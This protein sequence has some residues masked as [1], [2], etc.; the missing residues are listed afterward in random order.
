MIRKQLAH[1][2]S[3]ALNYFFNW[4]EYT[5]SQLFLTGVMIGLVCKSVI[6]TV[7]NS[8][9]Y[10]ADT[11]KENVRRIKEHNEDKDATLFG[12]QFKHR[13]SG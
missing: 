9:L 10:I 13:H 5:V 2:I 3:E 11:A 7:V 1:I 8:V 12:I 4:N 6:I